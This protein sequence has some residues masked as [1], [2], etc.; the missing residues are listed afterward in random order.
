MRRSELLDAAQALF[1]EQG[2]EATSVD[3][4]IAKVG[5]SK[6]TFY[7]YF[8]SKVDVLS[9]LADQLGEAI[10]AQV[11]QIAEAENEDALSK[12]NRVFAVS[13]STKVA[14]KELVMAL[15]KVFYRDGNVLLRHKLNNRT[16]AL[17]GPQFARIIRQGVA[18]GVFDTSDPD[19][20]GEMIMR[21]GV[22]LNEQIAPLILQLDE[23]PKN[24]DLLTGKIDV[25]EDAIARILGSP[26]GSIQVQD[27]TFFQ[28]LLK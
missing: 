20:A 13:R 15:V 21:L 26:P 6:G 11:G 2:Y 23:N 1:Y 17:A 12:L 7:Y 28:E 10:M 16:V 25:Y 14:N 18:E 4:I 8:D 9:G 5:V 22:D 27:R 3:A 24:L 19:D